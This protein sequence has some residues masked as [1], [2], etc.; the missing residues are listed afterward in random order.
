MYDAA[1]EIN[2]IE[3]AIWQGEERTS[4]PAYALLESTGLLFGEQARQRARLQPL[5]INNRFVQQL[6]MVETPELNPYARHHADL[7]YRFLQFAHQQTKG[8][9]RGVFIVPPNYDEQHMAVLLGVAKQCSFDAVGL[10][11]QT[12]AVASSAMHSSAGVYCDLQLHQMVIGGFEFID[13]HVQRTTTMSLD[14]FG[15]L[16]LH[17]RWVRIIA[18]AFIQQCRFD[19][20]HDA[21]I[22]QQL[23]DLLPEKLHSNSLD[24]VFQFDLLNKHHAKIERDLMLAPVKAFF[25]QL[26]SRLSSFGAVEQILCSHRLAGLPGFV[27]TDNR[28]QAVSQQCASEALAQHQQRVCTNTAT[29]PFITRLPVNRSSASSVTKAVGS[30]IQGSVE[31]LRSS[32]Q[33]SHFM[34]DD[35]AW[36]LDE[37]AVYFD[38]MGDAIVWTQ[39]AG[40]VAVAELGFNDHKQLTF[41]PLN[42]MQ[43]WLNSTLQETVSVALKKGDVIQLTEG[44]AQLRLIEVAGY[45]GVRGNE[46]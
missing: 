41:V 23:W 44:G 26:E 22:E 25:A 31:T 33:V 45:T 12:V 11:D 10:L 16:D 39:Q 43:Y 18:D 7:A 32:G 3:F 38:T 15:L 14:G 6:T 27:E 20:L 36:P 5:Q 9:E 35:A 1:V 4:I 40:S 46:A 28:I 17:E 13:D 29:L 30:S 37:G 21:A 34:I 8:L 42:G 2:D 19:P 24:T